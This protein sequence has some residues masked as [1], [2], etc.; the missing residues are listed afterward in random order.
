MQ[1]YYRRVIKSMWSVAQNLK[2]YKFIKDA[3]LQA[4]YKGIPDMKCIALRNRMEGKKMGAAKEI[5]METEKVVEVQISRKIEN[6]C[7]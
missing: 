3:D 7:R 5:Q 6:A 4:V 1:R 2:M